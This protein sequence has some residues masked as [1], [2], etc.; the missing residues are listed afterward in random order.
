MAVP[1]IFHGDPWKKDAD[2]SNFMP[3]KA[4]HTIDQQM[5]ELNILLEE[6]HLLYK[7]QSVCCI[8]FCWGGK[9]SALLAGTDKVS[10]AVVAHGSFVTQEDVEDVKKPILFLFAD[11]ASLAHRLTS[12]LCTGINGIDTINLSV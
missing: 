8:G 7:P 2:F 6:F 9:L 1:D 4:K 10:A 5:K 12:S 3:W 11:Q